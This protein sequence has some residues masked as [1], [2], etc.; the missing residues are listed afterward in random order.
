MKKKRSNKIPYKPALKFTWAYQYTL[1][2]HI[3]TF[4]GYR[5]PQSKATLFIHMRVIILIYTLWIIVATG[6]L[7]VATIWWQGWWGGIDV[8]P[9]L[10]G[11][12]NVSV[13]QYGVMLLYL[14]N[15]KES[16]IML[17][18]YSLLSRV[19]SHHWARQCNAETFPIWASDSASFSRN[20]YNFLRR[21]S[22]A[23][24]PSLV[25]WS[26]PTKE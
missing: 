22:E 3:Y 4:E 13:M 18:N 25:D 19:Y 23:V 20:V 24:L 17:Q 7:L 15:K 26:D 12:Q 9:S 5:F 11:V 6:S 2:H 14:Q 8:P 10:R 16:T 21:T 1:K